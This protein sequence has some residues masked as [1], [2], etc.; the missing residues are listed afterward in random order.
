MYAARTPPHLA[1][2]S[3]PRHDSGTC[4]ATRCMAYRHT[5]RLHA[6]LLPH[7]APCSY[8]RYDGGTCRATRCI[9]DRHTLRL[10]H[11]PP[12]PRPT[13]LPA[14]RRWHRPRDSAHAVSPHAA[15][16][17][18]LLPHRAPRSYLRYDGGTCRATRCMAYRHTLRLHARLP[19]TA[20]H[21]ATRDTTVP[22]AT[23]LGAWRIATRCGCMH[24]SPPHP[25][26]LP[27]SR[28]WHRP[29]GSVHG[30]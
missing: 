18:R 19:P 21:A 17:T 10:R 25:T 11:G 23:R 2:R 27:A 14:I 16:A 28:R 9:A 22:H 13:L 3:Y 26:P 7:R 29:R 20:P 8:P 12:P 4:H 30:G 24:G 6:R 15:V 5:L 1:P